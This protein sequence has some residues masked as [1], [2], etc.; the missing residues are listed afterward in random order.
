[1]W[2]IKLFDYRPNRRVRIACGSGAFIVE[3]FQTI[4]D[5]LIDYYLVHDKSKLQQLAE[6]T[7]SILSLK[8]TS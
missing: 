1:L 2:K 7:F 3:V 6:H 8:N 4:Q 5:I